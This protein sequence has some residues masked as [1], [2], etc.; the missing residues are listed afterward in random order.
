MTCHCLAPAIDLGVYPQSDADLAHQLIDAAE[1]V[2]RAIDS[3]ADISA[4][5]A[6]LNRVYRQVGD[7]YHLSFLIRHHREFAE[8]ALEAS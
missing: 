8:S 6:A 3:D 7:R 5:C 4:E 2:G 1:A